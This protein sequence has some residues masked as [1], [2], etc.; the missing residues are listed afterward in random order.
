MDS[1]SYKPIIG[2][3]QIVNAGSLYIPASY[4]YTNIVNRPWIPETTKTVTY[5]STPIPTLQ[6]MFDF[7]PTITG[8]G[9]LHMD[10]IVVAPQVETTTT[11]TYTGPQQ[12]EM[13]RIT[14]G[15]ASML[16]RRHN[17]DATIK[18]QV[19]TTKTGDNATLQKMFDFSPV[20]SGTGKLTMDNITI[21][22]QV[23]TTTTTTF[24]GPSKEE[25]QLI[26]DGLE[27]I[28]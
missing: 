15:I 24:H 10:N 26:A 13:D 21:A 28:L 1:A 11:T 6:T 7:S 14:A 12:R 9:Q 4:T 5:S 19:G 25:V 22:P 8:T 23:S 27:A 2:S 3:G 18:T 16:K 17:I 20:V